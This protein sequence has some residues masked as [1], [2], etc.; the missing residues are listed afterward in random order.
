ATVERQPLNDLRVVRGL[1][2]QR[3]RVQQV[4]DAFLAARKQH[5]GI[6]K[7]CGSRR[8]EVGAVDVQIAGIAGREVV[9]ERESRPAHAELENGVAEVSHTVPNGVPGL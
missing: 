8:S 4:E 7:E 1:L 2:A 5:A 9:D 3:V 6:W